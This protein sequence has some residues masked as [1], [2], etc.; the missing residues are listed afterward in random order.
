MLVFD[1]GGTFI[2]YAVFDEQDEIVL[3]SK[4][5]TPN[6][7]LITQSII[8]VYN[9]LSQEYS[10]E[11]IGISTAGQVDALKG[12][13]VFAGP[14][15]PGYTGT[16]LKHEI[17]QATGCKVFVE[18]DVTAC[19]YNFEEIDSMLYVALGTGIGGAYKVDNKVH[20]GDNGRSFEIGHMYHQ[21]GDTFENVCSTKSLLNNYYLETK[22]KISGE[23]L[24][25]LYSAND[26][27]ARTVVNQFIK[28]I[29]LGLVNLIHILDCNTIVLGGG[30]VEAKFFKVDKIA[31]EINNL[32]MM[33]KRDLNIS[34]S[35]YLNDAPLYGMNKYIRGKL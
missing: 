26:E 18:N 11:Q 4:I 19:I 21:G 12:E 31:D 7:N 27:V 5:T 30:V 16:K 34:I 23:Q 9:Q 17:E 1:V 15:I 13:V 2:K 29:A 6:G 25:K 14:T 22:Q 10:F 24:D 3:K 20:Y 33:S 32:A 35:P 28:D 8:D